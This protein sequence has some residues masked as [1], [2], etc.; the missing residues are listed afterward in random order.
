MS[1]AIN[2]F[3]LSQGI[4]PDAIYVCI[5][6]VSQDVRPDT[7][8]SYSCVTNHTARCHLCIWAVSQGILPDAIY[9]YSCVTNHTARC[10][11]CIWAVTWHTVRCCLCIWA[12]TRHSARCHSCIWA[13]S[14]DILPVYIYAFDLCHKSYY[15]GES[16]SNQ[17]NLYPGEIHLFFFDVMPSSVMHLGQSVQVPSAQNWKSQ[18]PFHWP[19]PQLPSRL[20]HQTGNEVHG[21]PFS[22]LVIG[23]SS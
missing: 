3:E 16:I 6:A 15:E 9:T 8:Y 12:V 13:V 4:Q 17:P 10:H 23:R 5:W 1:C 20:L 2:A 7:I 14:K 22:S 19:T 18:D 11:L 21:Y